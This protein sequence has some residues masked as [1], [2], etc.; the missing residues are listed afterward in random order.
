MGVT[1]SDSI[2]K[3]FPI[4][5]CS[6]DYLNNRKS[7][8]ESIYNLALLYVWLTTA[9]S[10]TCL[11]SRP[12][13]SPRSRSDSSPRRC[14]QTSNMMDLTTISQLELPPSV[15]WPSSQVFQPGL[16]QHV[17]INI[18]Y[19]VKGRLALSPPGWGHVRASCPYDTIG[20]CRR[21]LCHAKSAAPNYTDI[22]GPPLPRNS[23]T[24]CPW[25]QVLD[26]TFS[27][28]KYDSGDNC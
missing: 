9:S 8:N 4:V 7:P 24:T 13:S 16:L 25:G 28:S 21:C 17:H 27:S 10:Q 23:D 14:P 15:S 12:G 6:I 22:S 2:F 19:S 5:I 20:W 26:V 11:P 18:L 1:S 3:P